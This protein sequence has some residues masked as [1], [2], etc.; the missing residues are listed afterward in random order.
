MID[1][2]DISNM[3]NTFLL[4]IVVNSEQ[5]IQPAQK[6]KNYG[7]F[8]HPTLRSSFIS[9]AAL[10]QRNFQQLKLMFEKITNILGDKILKQNLRCCFF[11]R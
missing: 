1:S 6:H 10:S 4:I 2:T 3:L 7:F 5:K 8:V 9:N 11:Q